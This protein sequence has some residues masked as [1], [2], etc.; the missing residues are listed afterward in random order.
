MKLSYESPD[1]TIYEGDGILG[2]QH[3]VDYGDLTSVDAVLTDVPYDSATHAGARTNRRLPGQSDGPS[4]S[5]Q[6]AALS[7]HQLQ[8]C[9]DVWSMLS[10]RWVVTTCAIS[11]AAALESTYQ[12]QS[13]LPDGLRY[14]RTGAFV[15]TNPTPQVS[16]DRPGQGWEAVAH[17]Y[18][19]TG[20][21][22]WWG[23]GHSSVYTHP[24]AAG[25]HPTQK[26]D[27]LADQWLMRFTKPGDLV[28]DPF[29][30]SGWM[31]KACRR[32]G[33]RCIAFESDPQYVGVMVQGVRDTTPSMF[34]VTGSA[35][36]GTLWVA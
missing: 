36:Q 11:H 17:L 5:I 20:R 7:L 18:G 13:N 8:M 29:A 16:G 2:L 3:M 12:N 4:V 1:V 23:G 24:R 32:L 31:P 6:F 15:K 25:L 19:R 14:V 34:P 9:L 33:R 28:L 21:M 26:P 27:A 10:P 30:G 35:E 22:E